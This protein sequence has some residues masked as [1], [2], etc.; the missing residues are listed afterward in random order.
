MKISYGYAEHVS[1][2]ATSTSSVELFAVL[3]HLHYKS[4]RSLHS[5]WRTFAGLPKV[6]LVED[7][8]SL[9][10]SEKYRKVYIWSKLKCEIIR[11]WVLLNLS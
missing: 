7:L 9:D 4:T 8:G 6:E 3:L 5:P 11:T 2:N 1:S 10:K